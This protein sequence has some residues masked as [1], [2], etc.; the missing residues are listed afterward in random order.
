[1]AKAA[2]LTDLDVSPF[3][4]NAFRVCITDITLLEML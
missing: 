2:V 3:G 4:Q 1:M